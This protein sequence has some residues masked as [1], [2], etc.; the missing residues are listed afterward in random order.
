[1]YDPITYRYPR[2]MKEAFGPF[3]DN[4]LY[5]IEEEKKMDKIDRIVCYVCAIAGFVA[6]GVMIVWG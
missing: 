4:N 3:T 1:M 2:T 6:I 5:P